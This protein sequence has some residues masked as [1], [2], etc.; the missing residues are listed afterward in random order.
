M[1]H[2][3]RRIA[4]PI[5]AAVALTAAAPAHAACPEPD[6]A[7]I[8]AERAP[9]FDALKAAETEAEGQAI[10]GQIWQSWTTAP[11]ARAQA[12]LDRGVQRIGW[13]DYASAEEVLT[14]LIAYCP[15]Y[16]EGWNQRA[17]ARFLTGDLDG[18]LAD[19]DRV[20]ALEPRHFGALAGK[21]LTLL[22]QGRM[23]LADQAIRDAVALHPW[24]Q[25]RRFLPKGEK[26]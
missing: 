2:S 15:D 24:I 10:A 17:F 19:L 23:S 3:K 16:A 4:A 8:K 7:A 12:L 21:G 6:R 26:I 1:A 5:L 13:G 22:R 20:L 9:L 14:E 18:A 11:D 25:E